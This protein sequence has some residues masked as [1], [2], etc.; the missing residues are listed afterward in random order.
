[1][2]KTR[3][4]IVAKEHLFSKRDYGIITEPVFLELGLRRQKCITQL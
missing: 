2:H 4:K 3:W 1:M